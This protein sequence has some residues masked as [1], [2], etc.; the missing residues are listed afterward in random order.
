MIRKMT[1]KIFA[2][3]AAPRE[4]PVNP[5][6]PAMIEMMKAT[7]AWRHD[8]QAGL[9]P[10]RALADRLTNARFIEYEESGHFTYV[11]ESARFATDV[12]HF[13]HSGRSWE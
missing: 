6:A 13:L 12:T 2:I 1:K 8:Y 4:M 7:M 10:Q 5:S 11:D 9:D 3:L